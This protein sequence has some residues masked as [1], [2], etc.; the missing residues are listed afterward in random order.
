METAAAVLDSD[1]D[2]RRRS[3]AQNAPDSLIKLYTPRPA[4]QRRLPGMFS[5][6]QFYKPV[7]QR[8]RLA[9]RDRGAY[10]LRP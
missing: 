5:T 6:T 9:P 10:T 8:L 7:G 4:P 3:I 2:R 1:Q